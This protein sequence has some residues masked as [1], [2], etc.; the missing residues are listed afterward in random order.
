M[1]GTPAAVAG[2]MNRR[3]VGSA[4]S[5]EQLTATA[6]GPRSWMYRLNR[7]GGVAGPS[8]VVRHPSARSTQAMIAAGSQCHSRS[9][10]V[11]I[12]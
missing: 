12:T 5:T 8:W 6:S 3:V 2:S 7:I 10:Q 1:T 4:P 9:A 11:T